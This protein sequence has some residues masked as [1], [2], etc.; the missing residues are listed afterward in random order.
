MK[1][2]ESVL[3]K[4]FFSRLGGSL[5][6]FTAL[7]LSPRL[8]EV[9]YLAS[10]KPSSLGFVLR[11]LVLATPQVL[12]YSIPV[13]LTVAITGSLGKRTARRETT[14][15]LCSGV[16]FLSLCRIIILSCVAISL[17][18]LYFQFDLFPRSH[19]RFRDLIRVFREEMPLPPLQEKSLLKIGSTQIY[20]RTFDADNNIAHG[21]FLSQHQK[22]KRRIILAEQ[23]SIRIT[24]NSLQFSLQKGTVENYEFSSAQII[25][26]LPFEK[27]TI[28]FSLRGHIY[29][30]RVRDISELSLPE[31]LKEDGKGYYSLPSIHNEIAQKF[32]YAF[33]LLP[34]SLLVIG[35]SLSIR[36]RVGNRSFGMGVLYCMGFYLLN[37]L[38]LS[39][40]AEKPG[41]WVIL[42][43]PSLVFCVLAGIRWREFL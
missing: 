2:Y 37:I 4:D 14:V 36:G 6:L 25:D 26:I 13:A 39:L 27:F 11:I 17:F 20:F 41:G 38:S 21:V 23:G 29:P 18:L 1:I 10:S 9:F 15:F 33:S 22:D 16:S 31:L 12:V 5:C 7:F 28:N 30:D 35:T 19:T 43:L 3:G 32:F 40:V 8:F 24:P 42:G 34:F